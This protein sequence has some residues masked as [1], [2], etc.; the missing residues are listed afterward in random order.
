MVDDITAGGTGA[1]EAD[2]RADAIRFVT[3]DVSDEEAAA[4]T[5]VLLAA[6]D[7]AATI[8]PVA[9]PARNA[10]VQSGRALR[11]PLDVGPGAWGR[12]GR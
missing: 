12:S 9:D 8:A 10:W 4:V 3:R 2:V 1:D 5:A 6:L 11:T 7:E